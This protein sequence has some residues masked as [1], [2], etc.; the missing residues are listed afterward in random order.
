MDCHLPLPPRLRALATAV[1]PHVFHQE[2]IEAASKKVFADRAG[3]FERMRPF[4]GMPE[5]KPATPV[6][7]SIGI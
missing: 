6:L 3:A 7:V 5:S 2:D 1:P 4:T